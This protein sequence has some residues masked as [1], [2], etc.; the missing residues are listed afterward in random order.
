[1]FRSDGKNFNK[2]DQYLTSL[3]MNY[4]PSDKLTITSA[5]GY[6]KVDYDACQNYENSYAVILPSCNLYRNREFSQELNFS[7]DLEGPLNATGGLYYSN[8]EARDRIAHLPLWRPLPRLLAP[9]RD[10]ACQMVLVV[11]TPQRW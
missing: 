2:Q 4:Y 1:M 10:P 7:T 5:T 6:Y 11:P 8:V 3:V 9:P